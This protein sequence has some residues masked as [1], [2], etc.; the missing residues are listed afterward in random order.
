MVAVSG[1]GGVVDRVGLVTFREGPGNVVPPGRGRA[2]TWQVIQAA[3][4]C[5]ES[6]SGT[7]QIAA[8]IETLGT[9]LD[10]RGAV[11]LLSDFRDPEFHR[12]S[13]ADSA[14]LPGLVSLTRRHDVVSMIL[15]DPREESLPSVGLIRVEDP[16]RP[17]YSIVLNTRHAKV[18]A[19]Y[20]RACAIRR[21]NLERTLRASG[22]DVLWLRT[23]RDP[24]RALMHY[25]NRKITRTGLAA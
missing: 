11:I 25:F 24:L 14:V 2:H 22:T 15:H 19:R 17:G 6:A 7:T 3:V 1:G 12:P 8:A 21:S 16:E 13:R 18:R 20:Q 9:H 5:A 10:T 4:E 23:D